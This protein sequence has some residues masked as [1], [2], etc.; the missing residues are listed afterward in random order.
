MRH[1]YVQPVVY[2]LPIIVR[3]HHLIKTS[4]FIQSFICQLQEVIVT[5]SIQLITTSVVKQPLDFMKL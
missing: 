2:H 5:T 3:C 4:Y 1:I